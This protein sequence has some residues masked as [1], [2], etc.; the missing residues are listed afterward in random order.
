MA[1][2]T[3]NPG[4]AFTIVG[5]TNTITGTT[6]GRE[7]VTIL[8]GMNFF[9]PDF[10]AGGDRI[11]L[12]GSA[13]QYTIVRSGSSIVFS[14]PNATVVTFPA[15]NPNLPDAL[16]PVIRF[17][18]DGRDLM[19]DSTTAGVFTL[20]N[21]M[22]GTTGNPLPIIDPPPPLMI[23]VQTYPANEGD[24]I[25]YTLTLSAP[26]PTTITIG[27]TTAGTATPPLNGIVSDTSDYFPAATSVVFAAGQTTQFVTIE[28]RNDLM[29]EAAE[30]VNLRLDLPANVVLDQSRSNLVA[31][32]FDNDAA[33]GGDMT[34]MAVRGAYVA[35]DGPVMSLYMP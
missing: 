13:R 8:G 31:T 29:P 15:P 33:F 5:G 26:A 9:T 3:L 20:D 32:I 35:E 19:L 14:G 2:I 6:S 4:E 1:Q 27:V 16:N 25:V 12:A 28:T 23:S 10:N 24:T 18:G 17:V 22:I 30:T 7:T 21:A 34:V 11:V